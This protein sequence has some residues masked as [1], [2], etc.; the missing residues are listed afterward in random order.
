MHALGIDVGSQNVKALI[1]NGAGP[2][3]SVL[4]PGGDSAATIAQNAIEGLLNKAA[5]KREEA[6]IVTT[7]VGGKEITFGQQPK[8]ITT[9]LARGVNR[10]FPDARLIIDMGAETTTILKINPRG[11]VT[12]WVGQDK[13]A[14]GTGMFV[15]SMAKVMQVTLDEMSQLSLR[16]K[17][18]AEI[19]GTCAVFAES[20]VISHIHRVPPTPK[21]DIIAGIHASMVS[22][23]MGLLKRLGIEREVAVVG[24]VAHNQGIIAILEKELGFKVLVPENPEM[25]AA[26]GA[27]ILARESLDKGS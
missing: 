16:A 19:T 2:Q 12:D 6:F 14:A 7:G 5:I 9:C 4:L 22:R 11:R 21:E 3:F 15:Q 20:E 25:T 26:L 27:A 18:Q 24:G 17:G 8:A 23:V 1:L 10:L 13:C